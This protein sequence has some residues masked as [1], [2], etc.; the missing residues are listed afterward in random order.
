MGLETFLAIVNYSYSTASVFAL[1]FHSTLYTHWLSLTLRL[2]I[3]NLVIGQR[4]TKYLRNSNLFTIAFRIPETTL[5]FLNSQRGA[6]YENKNLFSLNYPSLGQASVFTYGSII[7]YCFF[8]LSLHLIK[9][10]TTSQTA[11]PYELAKDSHDIRWHRLKKFFQSDKKQFKREFWRLLFVIQAISIFTFLD[12]F[13]Q[14]DTRIGPFYPIE[15]TGLVLSVIYFLFYFSFSI[16]VVLSVDREYVKPPV[17]TEN[18]DSQHFKILTREEVELYVLEKI[19]NRQDD[20]WPR[21]HYMKH[22]E[23]IQE[24]EQEQDESRDFEQDLSEFDDFSDFGSEFQRESAF[25]YQKGKMFYQQ[26]TDRQ[27]R[28]QKQLAPFI[29]PK[30]LGGVQNENSVTIPK[31]DILDFGAIK[32]MPLGGGS[33]NINSGRTQSTVQN[34]Q[35]NQEGS[36]FGSDNS[37]PKNIEN[38]FYLPERIYIQERLDKK[39]YRGIQ[40]YESKV[41]CILSLLK[42]RDQ[43]FSKNAKFLSL[44]Y[45][46]QDVIALPFMIFSPKISSIACCFIFL[47]QE[48]IIFVANYLEVCLTSS[49]R[50]ARISRLLF[51][52]GVNVSVILINFGFVDNDSEDVTQLIFWFIFLVFTIGLNCSLVIKLSITL[53]RLLIKNQ[54]HKGEDGQEETSHSGSQTGLSAIEKKPVKIGNNITLR[55]PFKNKKYRY[56][57]PKADDSSLPKIPQVLTTPN[58]KMGSEEEIKLTIGRLPSVSK[59]YGRSKIV[60]KEENIYRSPKINIRR[61]RL[62]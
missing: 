20:I 33:I 27:G 13:D 59:K 52:L 56:G 3:V 16:L 61:L 26:S 55:D 40:F 32:V 37:M 6:G 49:S 9:I 53:Y 51:S 38:I 25:E 28:P 23:P 41:F 46:Y 24:E 42:N 34:Y 22:L 35:D 14:L 15:I 48:L 30:T 19:K 50:I 45:V 60:L 62:R 10:R 17:Q 5:T 36:L 47:A 18:K 57:I 39:I 8:Y 12:N 4:S 1:F 21:N 11:I 31:I 2:H 7:V 44:V 43:K 54:L 29:P 58:K